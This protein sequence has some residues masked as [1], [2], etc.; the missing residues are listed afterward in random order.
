MRVGVEWAF[1]RRM[2]GGVLVVVCLAGGLLTACSVAPGAAVKAPYGGT[3]STFENGPADEI[4][5]GNVSGLGEVL[6]D[7]EGL[8]LYQFATDQ[9]GAPS[10]CV[11]LCA[12]E[13]PPLTLPSGTQRPIAGPGIKS[14][15]LGTAPR[16]DGSIQI[17]YNGW[18]LYTWPQDKAPGEATGQGLTNLG[19][20]WWVVDAAGDG[21]HTP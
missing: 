17:T 15:L 18:P 21:V 8:T 20:R 3:K 16:S 2:A 13:W 5:I 4:K 12:V 6:V 10:K 1:R 14:S 11:G 9:Q 19:G 7:G